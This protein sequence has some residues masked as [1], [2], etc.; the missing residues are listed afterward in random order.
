MGLSGSEAN[1]NYYLKRDATNAV[2]TKAGTGSAIGFNYQTVAGTYTVVATNASAPSSWANMTGSAVVAVNARPTSVV[3]GSGTICNGGSQAI[4]AALTGAQLWTVTW[5]DGIVQ[6]TNASPA[7]R[8]VSPVA[9]TTYTVTNLTDANC[10]AQAGDQTGSA[11]VMLDLT[12]PTMTCASN[13]TVE[14]GAAWSFDPPTAL[15]AG[16]GTN[17]SVSLVASNSTVLNPCQTL[18]EGLWRATDGCSNST[19]CTQLVTV[20][21]TIP[22]L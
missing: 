11:V 7:T 17:V 9:T 2:E 19:V 14:C 20:V 10:T 16:C 13:K 5:S 8:M 6:T 21:D 22:P 18:W 3:S 15:G 12:P 4:Q 1:V